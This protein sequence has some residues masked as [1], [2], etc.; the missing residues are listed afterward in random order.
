ME[1]TTTNESILKREAK[2][3]IEKLKTQHNI[4]D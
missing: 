1:L 3:Q 4:E 2:K